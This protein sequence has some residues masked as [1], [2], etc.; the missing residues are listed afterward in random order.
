MFGVCV[1]VSGSWLLI[2]A[3][4]IVY[5]CASSSFN[6]LYPYTSEVFETEIRSLSNGFFNLVSRSVGAFAPTVLLVLNEFAVVIPYIILT[7]LSILS[8][9]VAMKLPLDTRRANLDTVLGVHDDT[10]N[11]YE[12]R[13]NRSYESI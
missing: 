1:I 3:L 13:S 4:S 5:F 10:S 12:R 8:F 7:G 9:I 11:V 2:V 6:A